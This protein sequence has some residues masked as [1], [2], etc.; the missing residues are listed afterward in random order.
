MNE[1]RKKITAWAAENTDKMV[2][3]IQ[4]FARI[5]SVSRADLAQENAPFGPE[6]REMLDFALAHAREMGFETQDHEGYCGSVM[7]GDC[8]ECIGIV[9]HLDVVPEGDKWIYPP[10][11]ATRVGDFLIGRGVADNKSPAIM[12]LYIMKMFRELGIEMKHGIR[13]ILGCSEETG[14]QD[15]RYYRQHYPEPKLS[16]IP[17]SSF[18]ANYAQK[19]SLSGKMKIDLGDDIK[20]FTGG[21]VANMVPPH[22]QA[23]LSGISAEAA[24]PMFGD[25]FTVEACDGGCVVKAQGI[26]AHAARPE[27]GKS[28]IN[29]LA[30]ALSESG[31][32]SGQSLKAARAIAEMTSDYY[33]GKAGIANEDPDTGKTTMVCGVAAMD[34][35]GKMTLSLDCRLSLAADGEKDIAVFTDYAAGLGFEAYAM[36]CTPPVY[37]PKDDPRMVTVTNLYAEITGTYVEPYTMGGGT[38]SRELSNAITFGPGFPDF[39]GRPEGLPEHHGGAHAPDEYM[40][41]SSFLRAFEVYA[42]AIKALD[43]VI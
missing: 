11:G 19:G 20:T 17:D 8:S 41:I 26:A 5:R 13:L 43:D 15:L 30:A 27:G 9:A 37:M 28:A 7:L 10:Y 16:L 3:D 12:G 33:G 38:Y 21:E 40:S 32:I 25:G 2:A 35:E 14:M 18:P 29:M 22:A 23:V 34:N 1:F 42:C 36:S 39:N 6:C 4:A 31:L 24:A